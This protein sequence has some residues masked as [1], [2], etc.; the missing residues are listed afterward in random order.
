MKALW[1]GSGVGPMTKQQ[2]LQAGGKLLSAYVSQTNLVEGMDA[3]GVDMDTLNAMYVVESVLNRL[4]Y[5]K[6]SRNGKSSDISI[7]YRNTKYI[8]RLYKRI[9]LSGEAERW[10]NSH[11]DCSELVVFVYGM[12]TPFL[13]AAAR[14]KHILPQSRICLIVPDLPQYMDLKMSPLKKALKAVDWQCIR[15]CMKIVDN[16]VLYAAPMADFLKLK[17]RTWLIME[18]SYDSTQKAEEVQ[19]E[20]NG[21]I[22]VMYSGALHL[23]HGIPELLDAMKL[24]DDNYELWLTGDGNAVEL[25]RQREKEDPRIRFFGYLPTRQDLLNK[26]AQ[27][28]MLISPR[29]DTEEASR[30]C[31][32]SKLFEY[33]ASGRPVISCYLDGI[34]EEYRA[35]LHELS[36]VSPE[37][38]AKTIRQVA[39]I[40]ECDRKA[41]GEKAREFVLNTKN[42]YAQAKKIAEFMG[43]VEQIKK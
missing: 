29:R 30:Y 7:G 35:Y 12:H 15:K 22:A 6:W 5:E 34:P 40:P 16:Y 23:R 11:Q 14:V 41:E 27:A 4:P 37:E 25:I 8:N 19:P 20:E 1:I 31:F 3:L 24:L 2:I 42:K 9:V 26:Q 13:A 10:A 18:G 39:G 33:M 28:T 38:I 32:P 17:P 43:V 36:G 21:K